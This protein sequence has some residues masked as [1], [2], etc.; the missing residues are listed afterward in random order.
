SNHCSAICLDACSIFDNILEGG[1][2][3][4]CDITNRA[5]GFRAVFEPYCNLARAF[6]VNRHLRLKLRPILH[7]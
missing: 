4:V 1:F 2:Y 6:A 7:E 5:T 3:T